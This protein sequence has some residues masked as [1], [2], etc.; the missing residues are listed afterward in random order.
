MPSDITPL[1]AKEIQHFIK[2]SKDK[3]VPRGDQNV[4]PFPIVFTHKKIALPR[5]SVQ[6]PVKV[7]RTEQKPKMDHRSKPP[8]WRYFGDKHGLPKLNAGKEKWVCTHCGSELVHRS[9]SVC[10]HMEFGCKQ[11]AQEDRDEFL[12][13][14]NKKLKTKEPTVVSPLKLRRKERDTQQ[15]HKLRSVAKPAITKPSPDTSSSKSNSL[16][17]RVCHPQN[18]ATIPREYPL[19]RKS[20]IIKSEEFGC[21][22][23]S[24]DTSRLKKITF[25]SPKSRFIFTNQQELQETIMQV[26]TSS[27][28]QSNFKKMMQQTIQDALLP[29]M[30]ERASL[31]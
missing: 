31:Q 10:Y 19:I 6:T 20:E 8:L 4:P 15:N 27:T 24:I 22:N 18:V 23:D 13:A 1:T 30:T 7:D 16:L 9:S 14:F 11:L 26:L 2:L 21:L 25:T 29:I 28:M 17:S 3:A 5:L 12:I